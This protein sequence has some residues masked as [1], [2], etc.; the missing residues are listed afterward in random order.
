M[1]VY[2][3]VYMSERFISNAVIDI[4]CVT[5]IWSLLNM[6][7]IR[8]YALYNNERYDVSNLCK[9]IIGTGVSAFVISKYL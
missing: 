9:T 1:I 2:I 8:Y 4:V 6:N 5:T 3:I 7:D